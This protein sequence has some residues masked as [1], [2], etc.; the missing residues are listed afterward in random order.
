[1]LNPDR[2]IQRMSPLAPR[3]NG[4]LRSNRRRSIAAT[5]IVAVAGALWGTSCVV[6]TTAIV[7]GQEGM[8]LP[9]FLAAG[10]LLLVS[11][12]L[13]VVVTVFVLTPVIYAVAAAALWNVGRDRR[14][15]IGATIL[16]AM[17]FAGAVIGMSEELWSVRAIADPSNELRKTAQAAN[18]SPM[19]FTVMLAGLCG[20]HAFA[21]WRLSKFWRA[22]E[23]PAIVRWATTGLGATAYGGILIW[24][25]AAIHKTPDRSLIPQLLTIGPVA[26]LDVIVN[27]QSREMALIVATAWYYGLWGTLLT[28]ASERRTAFWAAAVWTGTFYLGQFAVFAISQSL[29]PG[30]LLGQFAKIGVPLQST[31]PLFLTVMTAL[32]AW[33]AFVV[34][35][36]IAGW[37]KSP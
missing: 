32:V 11:E 33:Q 3:E 24:G 35:S 1:M 28:A 2:S 20:W 25:A 16:Y 26:F 9:W 27:H 22:P 4:F 5:T 34:T 10:P 29:V 21:W 7:V 6:V 17:F 30:M 19:L 12:R 14:A 18:N 37:K 31:G 36:L 13:P 23:R 8:Y 15:A